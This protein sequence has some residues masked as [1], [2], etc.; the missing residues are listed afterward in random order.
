M[1]RK[2][3]NFPMTLSPQWVLDPWTSEDYKIRWWKQ[4]QWC[5]LFIYA[6]QQNSSEGIWNHNG[7]FMSTGKAIGQSNNEWSPTHIHL[8]E[9]SE[10][11][12]VIKWPTLHS[13]ISETDSFIMLC[14][15]RP[16]NLGP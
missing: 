12:S 10:V 9:E 11:G 15:Q 14:D 5:G 1:Q 13:S 8:W 7:E 6:W 16:G 4:V 3:Q 2:Y